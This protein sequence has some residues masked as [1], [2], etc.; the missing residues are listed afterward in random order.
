MDSIKNKK[1]SS[2]F[3]TEIAEILHQ[4]FNNENREGFLITLT[5]VCINPDMTFIKGYISIYPF[6]KENIFKK[7]RSKSG[8]YRKLLSKKLRYR[9]KKIPKLDFRLE[10]SFSRKHLIE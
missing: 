2:I 3:Y 9:V 1:I 7:I 4:E 5:K 10:N 6:I 8:F